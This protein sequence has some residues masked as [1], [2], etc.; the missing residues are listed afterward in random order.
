MSYQQFSNLKKIKVIASA[1][2]NIGSF[3]T[4]ANTELKYIVLGMY[5]KGT[6]FASETFRLKLFGS[7]DYSGVLATSDWSAVSNIDGLNGGNWIGTVRFTFNRYPINKN[8]AYFMQIESANYARNANTKYASIVFDYPDPSYTLISANGHAPEI[9][10]V[11]Y[12]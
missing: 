3:D 1:T 8:F 2:E 12:E 10:I 4:T 5:F 7:S 9:R 6:G 11:G